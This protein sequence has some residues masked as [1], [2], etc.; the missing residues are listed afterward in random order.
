MPAKRMTQR[1]KKIRRE[2][3]K[4]WREQGILPPAK[5]PLNRKKFIEQARQSWNGR[6]RS[7]IWD[8]YLMRAASEMMGKTDSKGNVHP[9]AVGAAKVLMLAVRLQEFNAKLEEAGRSSYKVGELYEY[10][11]EIFEA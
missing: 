2:L 4:E 1:E 8:I 11:K 3:R 9:E 7:L 5:K 6:E 10:V